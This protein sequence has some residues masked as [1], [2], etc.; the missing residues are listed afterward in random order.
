[1][2]ED[3]IEARRDAGADS[4][5][6]AEHQMIYQAI[7]DRDSERARMLAAAHILG[8]EGAVRAMTTPS[9]TP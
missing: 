8:V 6:V 1:V 9:A 5:T 3:A 4:R 2:G 7:A